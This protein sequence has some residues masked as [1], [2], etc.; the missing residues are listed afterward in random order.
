MK[1]EELIKG[2]WYKSDTSDYGIGYMKYTHHNEFCLFCTDSIEDAKFRSGETSWVNSIM[3]NSLELLTDLSEIQQY[4][5]DGHEDKVKL[6]SAIIGA[7]ATK[8]VLLPKSERYIATMKFF[9][10]LRE[11]ERSEAIANYD[12]NYTDTIPSSLSFALLLGFDWCKSKQ[13]NSY[14]DKLYISI[15]NNT[16]F[17]EPETE[18]LVFGKY[19]VGDVV[20]SLTAY[21]SSRE[22][23]SLFT[24]REDS[25]QDKLRYD[26]CFGNSNPNDWRLATPEEVEAYNIGI[27]NIA[28]IKPKDYNEA[29]NCTTQEEWDFVL[30]KFN[31]QALNTDKWSTHCDGTYIVT[32]GNYVGCFGSKGYIINNNYTILTFKQWCDEY[33]HCY[34]KEE[35]MFKKGDYIV[36]LIDD[37]NCGK[38]NYC[39]KQRCNDRYLNPE[40]D[41]KGN[42]NNRNYTLKFSDKSQTKWRFATKEEGEEY[43]RHGKPYNV[44]SLLSSKIPDKLSPYIAK[45]GDYVEVIDAKR[46]CF[47]LGQIVKCVSPDHFENTNGIEQF[48]IPTDYKAVNTDTTNTFISMYDPFD[49]YGNKVNPLTPK[50]V[51][52]NYSMPKPTNIILKTKSKSIKL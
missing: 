51:Y 45:V 41:T 14:W 11:P 1:K 8:G 28:D 18:T 40:I 19:K 26:T 43:E 2:K 24:V 48:L 36:T 44:G 34:V 27:K 37:G 5:P 7:E 6:A 30:S 4:L 21:G 35:T 10:Q 23:G 46:N 49:M 16:Y 33:N 47:K 50:E 3:T 25:L 15:N 17:K 31:P 29:V 13:G 9:E 22:K 42:T 52:P 20:V 32:A 12:E 39:S 38:I